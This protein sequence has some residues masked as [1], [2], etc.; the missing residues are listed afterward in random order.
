MMVELEGPGPSSGPSSDR[1][2][3]DPSGPRS[4]R[5]MRQ[6]PRGSD[7]VP[8]SH[9][10][11]R[12]W[13]PYEAQPK[14]HRLRR[15][16]DR[17][18]LA[19]RGRMWSDNKGGGGADFKVKANADHFAGPTPLAVKFSAPAKGAKGD[20]LYRWRFDDGT[21]STEQNPATRSRAP[22]T[23]RWSSTRVTRTATRAAEP[24]VGGVAAQAVGRR[25]DQALHQEVGGRRPEGPAEAHRRPAQRA[26]REDQA[27]GRSI[28]PRPRQ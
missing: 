22:A 23:T 4:R 14:A 13:S 11:R 18:R 15:P 7:I 24:P 5:Y 6:S 25:A 17:G 1:F 20:V 10:I 8:A 19:R 21:S 26:A 28:G 27:R 12:N 2:E 9:G 3:A 16:C